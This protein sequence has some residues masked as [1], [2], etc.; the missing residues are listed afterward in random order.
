LFAGNDPD[1]PKGGK[2]MK[3]LAIALLS[4]VVVGIW[5]SQSASAATVL[6]DQSFESNT[7]GMIVNPLKGES[8]TRVASG[9]GILGVNSATGNYHAE[10]ALNG[11]SGTGVFTRNGGYSYTWPG[12]LVQSVSVYIDPSAGSVNDGW[13]LDTAVNAVHD[14][15]W[16]RGGGFGVQKTAAT[17]WSL[18]GDDDWGGYGLHSFTHSNTTPLDIATAGW[19]KLETEWVQSTQ[20]GSF[21]WIDQINNVYNNS[22]TLLWTDTVANVLSTEAGTELEIGGT[23]YSWVGSSAGNTMPVLAIDN[24]YAATP[25]PGTLVLLITAGLGMICYAWRRRTAR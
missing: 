3:R 7:D 1:L 13:F 18:L 24:V 2:K 20:A 9:E 21:Y 15:A 10:I 5:T 25:E 22:G 14:S 19:Y 16:G 17:T 12:Y 8:I 6:F 11:T 23:R 4:I